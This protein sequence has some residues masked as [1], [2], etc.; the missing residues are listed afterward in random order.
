[1]DHDATPLVDRWNEETAAGLGEPERLLYRSNLLGADPAITNFAGGNTSAKIAMKDPLTGDAVEVLWVK[2]SGGDLG[3]MRLDG[4]A[5]LSMA[6]LRALPALY[7]GR[8][9][10]DEMV[11]YLPHCTFGLNP[12]A[13]SIDTPLHAFIPHRHVD[14]MHPDAVIAIAAARDGE[15]LT[16]EI[17][18]DEIGWLPW[19]R[20]GFDL[21]MRIEGFCRERPRARGLMLGGHG[22]FTWGETAR[23]CYRNTLEVIGRAASH[24]AGRAR[25][26]PFGG[27]KVAALDPAARRGF[28]AAL[29]PVLRGKLGRVQRKVGH[30]DDDERVLAFVG[31]RRARELAEI[32]TSCPDHFLRTKVRPLL[33]DCDPRVQSAAEVAAGL[34]EALARYRA[35]YQAYYQ[36]CKHP[37]SPPLRDPSPV[38]CLVPGVGMFTF[39]RDK[40]TARVAG[41]FYR[42][43]I[44]VMRGATDVSEYVGLDEQEAFDIEYW[45]L[46]EAKLQR[47]PPPRPMV[48]RVAL[49]T[50]GAG[51]IGL[52]TAERLLREGAAV[53]LVDLDPERLN[54]AAG[55]LR[56]RFGADLVR[57]VP[58]D[59]TSETAVVEA[60]R[61]ACVEYGGVDVLVSSAGIASSAPFD[62]TSLELWRRNI[63]VLATGY[64]LVAREVFKVMKTQGLGGSLVLVASKNGLAASAN[65]V[66]YNVAKSS[67]IHLGRCLAVEGAPFGIRCNVVNP[68]AVLAGSHIWSGD[69]RAG[70]AA[71]YGVEPDQLEEYYRKRS[72]LGQPVLPEDVAEAIHFFASDLS[73][74]STGNIV[75]VDAGQPA[76]FTR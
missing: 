67:E 58:A 53:V 36:R 70:R 68:D 27:V 6:R 1:M 41:E 38:V 34:D 49:V 62:E 13:A 8:G 50:G 23:E 37:D 75:N 66:A 20:P 32:G 24:L 64:F 21:A 46:E 5:T 2:G 42:N 59:V 74:K 26:E 73:A 65:A 10:E 9:H 4:F 44:N 12:R 52:A 47:L 71:A 40:G 55:R 17:F 29:M 63:D 33:I 45:L 69:W 16:R 22:L 76:A 31:S 60:M 72:L 54:Q 61:A 30:F 7:R 48:G 57:A 43:A 18:G 51:G 11:G 14:H 39:A 28:A 35:E 3:S 56:G 15:A 25:A 19:Q